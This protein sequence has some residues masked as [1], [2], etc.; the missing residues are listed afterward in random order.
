MMSR[1]R[2]RFQPAPIP[3]LATVVLLALFVA[4]GSWQ[5]KRAGEKA[6]LQAQYD[7]RQAQAPV[8]LGGE[9]QDAE[10]LR[11]RRVAAT[12]H[13][14]TEY[15]ILLDNRVHRGRAGFHVITPLKLEGGERRL[16]VNRGW[17]ALGADRAQLPPVE[18][19]AGVQRILGLAAVPAERFFTFASRAPLAGA[20]EPLWQ[21][22]DMARYA[23]SVPFPVQPV[24]VLLDP[25]APGGFVREWA[26]LDAG[27]ATHRGY[28]FQWFALAAALIVL[29]A[30]LNLRRRDAGTR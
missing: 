19:P 14:E 30:A 29:Y 4:L 22:L 2:Y 10:A 13:Y 25:G 27:I 26:R 18:T 15:Q 20:W 3:T 7:A 11:F 28:A 8:A 6:A 9:A 24:V 17:I 16:L 12:G 5:L 23:A 1:R 21:N